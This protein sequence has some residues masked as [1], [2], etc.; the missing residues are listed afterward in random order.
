[1]TRDRYTTFAIAL[2]WLMAALIPVAWSIAIIVSDMPLSP[3]RIAGYSW[4]KWLG[5]TIFFMVVIRLIWRATHRVPKL[6]LTMTSWQKMA[7]ELTHLT[8]Y[9]LMIAVP[10]VGWLM[11]SAKGYT[12]NYF[13][14]FD[15]PDLV[16]KNK[17]LGDQLREVH[18]WLANGLMILVGVHI[19]AALKHHFIDKDGLLNRMS[20]CRHNDSKRIS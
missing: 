19:L 8:L 11:S 2:H 16:N 12:V 4:H 7:M 15:L 20:F 5:T 14:L 13:G 1:M 18:E 3:A 17:A 9:L 10:V 6:N